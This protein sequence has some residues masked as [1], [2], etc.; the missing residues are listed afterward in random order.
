MTANVCLNTASL[1]VSQRLWFQVLAL[2]KWSEQLSLAQQY[3]SVRI[4]LGIHPYFLN[5]HETHHLSALSDA[6]SQNRDAVVA[7]GECGLDYVLD[8]SPAKQGVFFE[9]QINLA[10]QFKLPLILHHRKSHHDIIGQLK[11]SGFEHGGVIHAFSGSV[12]VAREYLNL[13]FKLG[14]GGLITYPRGSRLRGVVEAVGIEHIVLETDAP[15]MPLNTKQGQRNTPEYIP[16]IADAVGDCLGLHTS[17]VE[18]ATDLN[19]AEVFGV[20]VS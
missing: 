4:A 15:D 19:C 12:E 10:T 14:I 2:A 3:P 6:I 20:V 1:L 11:R 17:D 16:L 13:G 9:Q 7:V 5:Q 18:T 8:I